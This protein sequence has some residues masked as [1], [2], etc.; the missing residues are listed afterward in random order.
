M[1]LCHYPSFSFSL[2]PFPCLSL[3]FPLSLVFSWTTLPLFILCFSISFPIAIFF[4]LFPYLLSSSVSP[5]SISPSPF[6]FS[7][8]ISLCL[9]ISTFLP[10]LPSA[11]LCHSFSLLLFLFPSITISL[12]PTSSSLLCPFHLSTHLSLTL[13]VSPPSF[14]F[15]FL[16][17]PPLTHSPH[18]FLSL[19]FPSIPILLSLHPSISPSMLS[20][21]LFSLPSPLPYFSV[22]SLS[23]SFHH[24]YSPSFFLSLII[25]CSLP[26]HPAL[27]AFLYP[28]SSFYVS[29]FFSFSFF[30]PTLSLPPC[31]ILFLYWSV[32]LCLPFPFFCQSIHSLLLLHPLSYLLFLTH[33]ILLLSLS[34]PFHLPPLSFSLTLPLFFYLFSSL[35]PLICT[36]I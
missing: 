21:S 33:T 3:F 22:V 16:S 27:T 19:S 34:F 35:L 24:P 20:T 36:T 5:S 28:S 13:S 18:L 10:L 30:L 32:S 12:H 11:S 9:S 23:L 2:D 4:S 6:L 25:Y 26:S 14:T 8:H 7:L 15:L 31:L 17:P 29:C 1:L